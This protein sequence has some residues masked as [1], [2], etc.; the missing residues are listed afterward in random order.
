M[1]KRM[2]LILVLLG[3]LLIL[4]G[5]ETVREDRPY[6]DQNIYFHGGPSAHLSEN[7]SG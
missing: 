7:V 2:K 4:T 6:R 1:K 5:C 3:G